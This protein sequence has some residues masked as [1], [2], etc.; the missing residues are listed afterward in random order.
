MIKESVTWENDLACTSL[1]ENKFILQ[2]EVYPTFRFLEIGKSKRTKSIMH[3]TN[4]QK[5]WGEQVWNSKMTSYFHLGARH[6]N[7]C[8]HRSLA[9]LVSVLQQ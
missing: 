3:P 9:G 1:T 7:F 6:H 4:K 8:G 2:T 5:T